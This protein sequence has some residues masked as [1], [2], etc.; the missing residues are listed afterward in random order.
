MNIATQRKRGTCEISDTTLT[1]PELTEAKLIINGKTT[2][3]RHG[4]GGYILAAIY[5]DYS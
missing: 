2:V 1:V 4:R 5:D 3:I